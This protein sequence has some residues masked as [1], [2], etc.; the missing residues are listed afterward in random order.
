M[1]AYDKVSKDQLALAAQ[2]G[3]YCAY[4]SVSKKPKTLKKILKGIYQKSE[5]GSRVDDV[6][7]DKFLT[8]KKAFEERMAVWQG[9]KKQKS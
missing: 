2:T 6:D 8:T 9:T 4:F 5:R 1:R 7:V 3:F